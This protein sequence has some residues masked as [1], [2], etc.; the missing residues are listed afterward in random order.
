MFD[1]AKLTGP[2]EYTAF[3]QFYM[4]DAAYQ[5]IFVTDVSSGDLNA[6]LID[7]EI[8]AF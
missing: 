8:A 6:G 3:M 2:L 4:V 5:A 1:L 7:V